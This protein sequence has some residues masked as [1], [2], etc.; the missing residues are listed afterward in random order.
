MTHTPLPKQSLTIP[1]F[2]TMAAMIKK[3]TNRVGSTVYFKPRLSVCCWNDFQ[4]NQCLHQCFFYL[5]CCF[6]SVTEWWWCHTEVTST[7]QIVDR[8][9][10]SCW[11]SRGVRRGPR[12]KGWRN[13]PPT[14][15]TGN[16]PKRPRVC[17][18]A[19]TSIDRSRKPE[20]HP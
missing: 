12:R 6:C 15:M 11:G 1:G 2:D 10:M 17:A 16:E 18:Q 13:L 9:A 14:T 7:F 8:P 19:K 4:L 5:G 20:T 3:L